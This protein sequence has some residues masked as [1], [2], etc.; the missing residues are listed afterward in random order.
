[1]LWLIRQLAGY[2]LSFSDSVKNCPDTVK[3]KGRLSHIFNCSGVCV[4]GGEPPVLAFTGG[5]RSA[6]SDA[7]SHLA[8]SHP[9]VVRL[10]VLHITVPRCSDLFLHLWSSLPTLPSTHCKSFSSSSSASCRQEAQS[11]DGGGAGRPF[12]W[13]PSPCSSTRLYQPQS[14]PKALSFSQRG[15]D[16]MMT[17]RNSDWKVQEKTTAIDQMQL[18]CFVSFI[19]LSFID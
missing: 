4:G 6:R 17:F 15:G 7:C 13:K 3:S 2:W 14:W 10:K 16:M 11:G 8:L 19:S 1:M 18:C 5:W 12:T 9:S